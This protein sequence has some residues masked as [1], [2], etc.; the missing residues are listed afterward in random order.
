[1]SSAFRAIPTSAPYD[2]FI[3][4]NWADKAAVTS[5]DK[6]LTGAGIN[7]CIDYRH[8]R[9]GGRWIAELPAAIHGSGA[10]VVF[11]GPEGYGRTQSKEIELSIAAD[12]KIIPVILPAVRE[13]VDLPLDFVALAFA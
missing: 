2:A 1:M 5:Y 10:V 8:L 12:K 3:S 7:V 13:N 6:D 11:Y 4:Y 9:P